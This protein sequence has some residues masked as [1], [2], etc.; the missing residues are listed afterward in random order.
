MKAQTREAETRRVQPTYAF[1]V[2]AD[3]IYILAA[4]TLGFPALVLILVVGMNPGVQEGVFMT[5]LA[6]LV[7]AAFVVAAIFEIRR[8]ADGSVAYPEQER[9]RSRSS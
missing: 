8:L 4:I 5:L 3:P 9:E 2:L 6:I 1:E 7:I